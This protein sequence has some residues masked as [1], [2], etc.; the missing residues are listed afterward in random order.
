MSNHFLHYSLLFATGFALTS[1]SND[2]AKEPAQKSEGTASSRPVQKVQ[3]IVSVKNRMVP[4]E[5]RVAISCTKP[6]DPYTEIYI[7]DDL[8]RMFFFYNQKSRLIEPACSG[9]VS[10]NWNY[11][12]N[13]ISFENKDNGFVIAQSINRATGKMNSTLALGDSRYVESSCT[14]VKMPRVTPNKF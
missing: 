2:Q 12:T 3:P 8:Q 14:K 6:D 5:R 1:C 10:C 13:R 7:I 4:T 9:G 11:T